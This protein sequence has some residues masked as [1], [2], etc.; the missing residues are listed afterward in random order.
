MLNNKLLKIKFEMT[1]AIVKVLCCFFPINPH[2][3]SIV[4]AIGSWCVE[5]YACCL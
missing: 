3:L 5:D 1:V 4:I 2:Q